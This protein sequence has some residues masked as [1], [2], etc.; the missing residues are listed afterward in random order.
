MNLGSNETDKICT[1][2]AQKTLYVKGRAG[3]PVLVNPG[4]RKIIT[5]LV[6]IGE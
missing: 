5:L 2:S 6:R 1:S 4:H 3:N